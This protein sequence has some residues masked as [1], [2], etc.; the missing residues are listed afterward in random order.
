[1]TNTASN[2]IEPHLPLIFETEAN[3]ILQDLMATPA[4]MGMMMF[5]EEEEVIAARNYIIGVFDECYRAR[6][7]RVIGVGEEENLYGY[8]LIFEHPTE[9]DSLYCHKIFVF[10]QYRGKG[11][12]SQMLAEILKLSNEVGLVCLPDLISFYQS[13]GMH[14]KGE[15]NAPS[16]AGFTKTNGMYAGLCLMSTN[17]RDEPNRVPIFMLNDSDIDNIQQALIS[18]KR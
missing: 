18:A 9:N 2:G 12:G 10:E 3:G 11:I 13:A 14:F 1:M 8:A 7:L 15:F 17:D 6:H 4:L 16:D 5:A